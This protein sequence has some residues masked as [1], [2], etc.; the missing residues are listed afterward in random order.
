MMINSLP[1]GDSKNF[2]IGTITQ[3][4]LYSEP[5]PSNTQSGFCCLLHT[6]LS[7]VESV[8]PV[9]ATFAC[10]EGTDL[11]CLQHRLEVPVWLASPSDSEETSTAM[12]V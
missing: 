2:L 12:D 9:V 10:G 6:A 3:N 4:G 1:I 11:I 5:Q 8:I 7:G